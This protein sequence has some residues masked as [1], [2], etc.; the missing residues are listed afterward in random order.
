MPNTKKILHPLIMAMDIPL[1]VKH[2]FNELELYDIIGDEL[3]IGKN[4]EEIDESRI[5]C[6]SFSLDPNQCHKDDI[7]QL[8]EAIITSRVQD[9]KKLGT[10]QK[11]IFYTWYDSLSGSFYLSLMSFDGGRPPEKQLPFGCKINLVASLDYIIEDFLNDS[12]H[13]VIPIT[14]LEIIEKSRANYPTDLDEVKEE[15]YSVDVWTI[16]LPY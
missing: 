7:S 11:A 6:W 4:N 5:N 9:L 15:K 3:I 13:G 10:D 14:E 1:K 16:I 12:Y 2:Y 8:Y